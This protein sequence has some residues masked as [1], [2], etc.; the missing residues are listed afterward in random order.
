MILR[1]VMVELKI[2][3]KIFKK[4]SVLREDIEHALLEG[5]PRYFKTKGEKYIALTHEK[6]YLTIV[7]E[8]KKGNALI[9]TAYPSSKWQ[10]RPYKRK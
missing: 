2:E 9:K 5:N 1:K 4:H 7:F 8:Y 6:R 3:E 10:R